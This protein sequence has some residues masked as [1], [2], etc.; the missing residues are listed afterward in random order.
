MKLSLRNRSV[1]K[2][3]DGDLWLIPQFVGQ[4][5]ANG[6]FENFQKDNMAPKPEAPKEKTGEYIDFEEIK[7]K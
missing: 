6:Q 5:Q 2:E 1:T 4:R 7:E 3:T